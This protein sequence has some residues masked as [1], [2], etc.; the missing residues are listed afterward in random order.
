MISAY[1]DGPAKESGKS[2]EEIE[3][4]LQKEKDR[5]EKVNSWEEPE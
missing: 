3:E 2:L 4:D 5:M 1:Y